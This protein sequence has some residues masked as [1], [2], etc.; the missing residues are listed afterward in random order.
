MP[1]SL[2][3]K[4]WSARGLYTLFFLIVPLLIIN[5]TYGL[6]ETTTKTSVRITGGVIMAIFIIGFFCKK[7]I[8]KFIQGLEPGGL[9]IFLHAL[10]K[11]ILLLVICV[12]IELSRDAIENFI[13]CFEF[14]TVSIVASNVAEGYE[15]IYE[16]EISEIKLMKRQ[17]GYRGK[18]NL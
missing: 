17:D 1:K 2:L 10:Y 9:R 12:L 13:K 7:Y 18:Y 16:Q 5:S 11:S 3:A 14:V 8:K 15:E 4:L 6:F